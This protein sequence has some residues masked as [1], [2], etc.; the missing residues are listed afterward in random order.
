MFGLNVRWAAANAEYVVNLCCEREAS[1]EGQ[2][3][4]LVTR[5][6]PN[7]ILPFRA[8]GKPICSIPQTGKHHDDLSHLL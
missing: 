4:D 1:D 3:P 5:D 8:C 6:L 2:Y 7:G